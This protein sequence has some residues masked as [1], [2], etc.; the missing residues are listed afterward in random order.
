MA[1]FEREAEAKEVRRNNR[2]F[3]P[4]D[5]EIILYYIAKYPR[6]VA[7]VGVMSE[8]KL[9][10]G[11]GR[12]RSNETSFLDDDDDDSS[13]GARTDTTGGKHKS[14]SAMIAELADDM[15]SRHQDWI[16][17]HDSDRAEDLQYRKDKD[18]E[19]KRYRDER[20]A[21]DDA[22]RKQVSDV[23]IQKMNWADFYSYLHV[24]CLL[25]LIFLWRL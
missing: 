3:S 12:K 18:A 17:I 5:M 20:D 25:T 2:N 9:Y 24:H 11:A 13:L 10:S 15:A 16:R 22:F 1:N 21:K 4:A 19:D 6:S 23:L 8:V 14:K 7:G